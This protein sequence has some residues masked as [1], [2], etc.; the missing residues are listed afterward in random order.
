MSFEKS[1]RMSVPP[2]FDFNRELRKVGTEEVSA[3][4]SIPQSADPAG[5]EACRY[6]EN[7]RFIFASSESFCGHNLFELLQDCFAA[8]VL[9]TAQLSGPSG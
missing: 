4:G 9:L 7:R 8:T 6:S 3:F 2:K 1:A 5:A